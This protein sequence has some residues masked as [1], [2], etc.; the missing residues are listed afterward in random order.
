MVWISAAAFYPPIQSNIRKSIIQYSRI[1]GRE[2]REILYQLSSWISSDIPG[3]ALRRPTMSNRH[4]YS[5]EDRFGGQYHYTKWVEIPECLILFCVLFPGIKKEQ[6]RHLTSFT[7]GF[8]PS[9]TFSLTRSHFSTS[10]SGLS[11]APV[12]EPLF[13]PNLS[14]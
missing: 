10:H 14:R 9:W 13:Y 1:K 8:P 6:S 11:S 2:N 12:S 5:A 7:P 4:P 3:S